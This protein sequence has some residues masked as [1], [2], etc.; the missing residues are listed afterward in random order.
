MVQAHCSK[1]DA[2]SILLPPTATQPEWVPT[3]MVLSILLQ[4]YFLPDVAM[5]GNCLQ[6]YLKHYLIMISG[7]RPGFKPWVGYLLL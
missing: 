4:T 3:L 2:G 1:L 6:L 5:D 7:V